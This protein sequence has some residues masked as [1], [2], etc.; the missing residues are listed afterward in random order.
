MPKQQKLFEHFERMAQLGL[1]SAGALR[2]LLENLKLPA[3]HLA[4]IEA[5]EQ[6]ADDVNHEALKMLQKGVTTPFDRAEIFE[7]LTELDDVVDGID[8][9][10]HRL[11]LYKVHDLK[12]EAV[13][14][15]QL[16][17]SA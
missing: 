1:E 4:R 13:A 10:A 7:L 16:V 5:L 12:P 11:V 14:L 9:A 17:E 3:E 8:V 15:A 2:K 6:Q